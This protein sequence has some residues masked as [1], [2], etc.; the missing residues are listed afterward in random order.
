MESLLGLI[1]LGLVAGFVHLF[2]RWQAR[3]AEEQAQWRSLGR[4]LSER[5]SDEDLLI[6]LRA[7]HNQ[8]L[9][10]TIPTASRDVP[11]MLENISKGLAETKIILAKWTPILQ[12]LGRA[13]PTLDERFAQADPLIAAALADLAPPTS[14][15]PAA[16]PAPAEPQTKTT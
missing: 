9:S 13:L 3:E 8:L 1:A 7:I 6:Q 4:V 15:P 16:S 11:P 10:R 2:Q 5:V 12:E 14:A